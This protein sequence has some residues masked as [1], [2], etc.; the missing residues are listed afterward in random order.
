MDHRRSTAVFSA[1]QRQAVIG[2]KYNE[3]AFDNVKRHIPAYTG[4]VFE[5]ICKQYMWR[6]NIADRLP[7]YFRDAGRWWGTNPLKKCQ[8][9]IDIIA[10][11]DGR[12]IFCECKWTKEP[13]EKD[14]VDTL[15]EKS[16]MFNYKEKHFFVFS[17]SGFTGECRK[18]AGSNVRLIKFEDMV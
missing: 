6:E 1:D 7:F 2:E 9:E 8:Q 10:F 4:E 5:E 16:M 14:V 18:N 3:K 13:V 15:I 12:A 17:K 11:D